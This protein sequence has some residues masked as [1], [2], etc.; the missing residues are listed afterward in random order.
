MRMV[1]DAKAVH[2]P[3]LVIRPVSGWQTLDLV[4]LWHFRSL[5]W[6]LGDR[7]LKLRYRQTLLG[8][9]WV[10]L[11]PL[12]AAAIFAVVFGKVAKLPSDGI[13]YF[14]FSYAGLLAWNAFNGILGRASTSLVSNA[15]MVSK[16]FF[17]RLV[18]PL[19]TLVSNGVDFLVGLVL[20]F[21]LL[22]FYQIHVT[23]ALLWLPVWTLLVSMLAM[24]LGLLAAALTVSYRDVQYV[25]PVVTQ[26][27]LYASPVAYSLSAVP[28][29][30]Q[31]FFMVNPL[32]GLLEAFRWSLLGTASLPLNYV[33]Y[34]AGVSVLVLVVGAYAFRRMELSFA[35]V[36]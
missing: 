4:E 7:D 3:R 26:F 21:F 28:S 8:V 9:I 18:L 27:L 20:L 6:T 23:T 2:K 10:V 24:G 15:Q 17:P 13:P 35:D 5:F 22:P 11:Q 25:L 19:A 12:L 36:I 32:S 34:S 29:A 14:I 33:A 31:V 1:G 16:V 30:Y